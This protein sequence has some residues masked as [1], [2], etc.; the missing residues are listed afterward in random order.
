MANMSER[1]WQEH[2]WPRFPNLSVCN[3]DH[4]REPSIL[5]LSRPTGKEVYDVGDYDR[6][7]AVRLRC[8]FLFL[9]VND[10]SNGKNRRMSRQLQG[11]FYLD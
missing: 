3:H 5:L 10:I 7:M 4:L 9:P 8:L 1:W 2:E 11:L 6:S